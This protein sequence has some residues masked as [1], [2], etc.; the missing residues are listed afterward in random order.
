M[1]HKEIWFGGSYKKGQDLIFESVGCVLH[2]LLVA[3]HGK[4]WV[5][6]WEEVVQ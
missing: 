2:S 6:T 5:V 1:S 4:G 3:G